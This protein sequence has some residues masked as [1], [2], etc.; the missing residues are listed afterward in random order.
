MNFNTILIIGLVVSIAI[1][2]KPK[3][4]QF[5]TTQWIARFPEG[6][7]SCHSCRYC[8]QSGNNLIWN[9]KKYVNWEDG[10][11]CGLHKNLI[12]E[13]RSMYGKCG[14]NGENHDYISG[15]QQ[16]STFS[17]FGCWNRNARMYR[18]T[19]KQDS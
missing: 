10:L 15:R 16:R 13:E 1:L 9:G 14:I 6:D 7:T 4:E 17:K 8:Y 12:S 18:L 19:K 3:W 11:M 5:W 2:L